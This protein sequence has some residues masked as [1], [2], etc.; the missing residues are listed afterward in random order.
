MTPENEPDDAATLQDLQEDF[1]HLDISIEF[2]STYR[3][4]SA[5]GR[6]GRNP[7]LVFKHRRPAFPPRSRPR[8]LTAVNQGRVPSELAPT[9]STI[10]HSGHASADLSR[11]WCAQAGQIG[12]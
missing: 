12:H 5:R 10:G 2:L 7:W 4:W 3:A 1:P 11:G 9:I 8:R 6:D